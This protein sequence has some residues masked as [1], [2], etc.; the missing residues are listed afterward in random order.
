MVTDGL[1]NTV[2]LAE[3]RQGSPYDIR[4]VIWTSVPGAGSY[5]TRFTPNGSLDVYLRDPEAVD[6]LPD[7]TLC[8]SE[9]GTLLAEHHSEI[10]PG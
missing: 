5:M 4:G 1:S 8:V 6:E 10:G 3:I 9:S 2:F 7:P